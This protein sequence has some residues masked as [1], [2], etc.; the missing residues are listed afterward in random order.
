MTK[1][2]VC[3]FYV[4]CLIIL[5]RF[6]CCSPIINYVFNS[7]W[8]FTGLLI[9]RLLFI[10]LRRQYIEN[11]TSTYW[12]RTL[13]LVSSRAPPLSMLGCKRIQRSPFAGLA[14]SPWYPT[15][16]V[17]CVWG[18]YIWSLNKNFSTRQKAGMQSSYYVV[19]HREV[20]FRNGWRWNTILDLQLMILVCQLMKMAPTHPTNLT[21]LLHFDDNNNNIMIS[22]T[23]FFLHYSFRL[24]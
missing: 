3:S 1:F 20:T 11:A 15:W 8:M 19:W 17:I 23:A 13:L 6:C 10:A 9:V 18:P 14:Q 21:H 7:W 5:Y 24:L 16:W 4:F 2:S 12:Q 22:H